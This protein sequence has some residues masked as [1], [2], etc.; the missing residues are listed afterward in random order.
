MEGTEGETP[1]QAPSIGKERELGW[2]CSY[3][4]Q[5]GVHT[6]SHSWA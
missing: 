2:L 3:P 5:E 1:A 6:E 4:A